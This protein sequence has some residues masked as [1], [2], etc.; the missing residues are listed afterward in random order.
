LILHICLSI[1]IAAGCK[2]PADP[3]PG[4]APIGNGIYQQLHVLGE[5]ERQ[6][7]VG[8]HIGISYTVLHDDSD[9]VLH[10]AQRHWVR[11]ERKQLLWD[12]LLTQRVVGDSLSLLM[13]AGQLPWDFLGSQI[14][15]KPADSVSLR[16]SLRVDAVM[17]PS[18]AAEEAELYHSWSRLRHQEAEKA[19]LQHMQDTGVDIED[20]E[21][22]GVYVVVEQEG[23]GEIIAFGDQVI[24][25]YQGRFL[26]EK[27][28]DDTYA[29]GTPLNFKVGVQGQVI[30]GLSL[31]VRK[32]SVGS[33]ARIYVPY[34]FGFGSEGSSTGIVPPFSNLVYDVDVKSMTRP[35]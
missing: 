6:P 33:K 30:W 15:S 16:L 12:T 17:S 5:G 7:A 18:E 14:G 19:L 3:H 8:D 29:S 9:M 4:M 11:G 35:E 22:A 2:E 26:N 25:D 20:A 10:R 1:L 21:F 34:A 24:M 28:F 31:A 13:K 32:L 23:D 27:V